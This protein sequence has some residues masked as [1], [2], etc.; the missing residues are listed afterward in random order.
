MLLLGLTLLPSLLMAC[1]SFQS[2]VVALFGWAVLL[3]TGSGLP[4]AFVS[5]CLAMRAPNRWLDTRSQH[6]LRWK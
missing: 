3:L 1:F 6:E 4:S 5:D 2:V